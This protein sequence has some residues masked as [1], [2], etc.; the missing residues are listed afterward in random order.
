VEVE[1]GEAETAGEEGQIV[2]IIVFV[3]T[4]RVVG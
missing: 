1:T 3:E 2:E 4:I